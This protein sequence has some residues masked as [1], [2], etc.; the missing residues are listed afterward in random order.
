MVTILAPLYKF[1]TRNACGAF[2]S[3]QP[4]PD[5]LHAEPVLRKDTVGTLNVTPHVNQQS[6]WSPFKA[7]PLH[8]FDL[9]LINAKI[10]IH[11]RYT[12][13]L[14]WFWLDLY[15]KWSLWEKVKSDDASFFLHAVQ[16]LHLG[17][18]AC[19]CTS[20]SCFCLLLSVTVQRAV[21]AAPLRDAPL[22]INLM[23]AENTTV[24]FKWAHFF[25]INWNDNLTTSYL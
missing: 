13:W 25:K 10:T 7:A 5:T 8:C 16:S 17:N 23:V 21:S 1:S 11:I 2:V 6:L 9:V 18:T 15:V 24:M 19:I 12:Q 20:H 14:C 4:H 3:R 22:S